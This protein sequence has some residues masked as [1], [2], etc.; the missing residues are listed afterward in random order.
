M[1]LLRTKGYWNVYLSYTVIFSI[2]TVRCRNLGDQSDISFD[3]LS[4][5]VSGFSPGPPPSLIP[6]NNAKL[7]KKISKSFICASVTA[8]I[9]GC[10]ALCSESTDMSPIHISLTLEHKSVTLCRVKILNWSQNCGEVRKSCI[11]KA[12]FL[13]SLGSSRNL[14]ARQL[15]SALQK[16][17]YVLLSFSTRLDACWGKI[18]SNM[19]GA[20]EIAVELSNAVIELL[21]ERF[22]FPYCWQYL[23]MCR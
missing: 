16:I 3:S 8:L 12:M 18:Y 20:R 6:L 17:I 21:T 22:D 23:I 7:S 10:F 5:L 4:F 2:H 19:C 14:C 11:F 13:L 15:L 9:P 1:A